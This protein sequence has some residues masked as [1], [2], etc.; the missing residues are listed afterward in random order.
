MLFTLG[1]GAGLTTK[2]VIKLRQ[3]NGRGSTN[4]RIRRYADIEINTGTDMTLAQSAT[5][6]DSITI[7]TA[8]VYIVTLI[9]RSSAAGGDNIGV[10]KNSNQLTT[11]IGT[12]T[13][14]HRVMSVQLLPASTLINQCTA[15]QC[16]VN[17]V[18]R[19][20]GDNSA[21]YDDANERTVFQVIGP[22]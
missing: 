1:R 7:N 10:S 18:L 13:D 2:S 22:F 11:D 16:E 4:T 12:I 14:T 8:G 5:N 6:G 3:G 20:H 17:D 19:A 9:E 15:V 21:N